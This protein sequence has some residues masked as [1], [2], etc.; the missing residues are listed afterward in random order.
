[1]ATSYKHAVSV[2]GQVFFC[3]A[4]IR[5]DAYDGCQFGCVY[6]FS[7]KRGRR[8]ND[9][10]IHK[11]NTDALSRRFARVRNGVIQSALDEFIS[12]RVP[13]QLGG[14]HDP[15]TE[16]ERNH[17][18]TLR[19]LEILNDYNYPTLISTKG[20][21]FSEPE[22][23]A[24]LQQMNVLVRISASGI[25]EDLRPKVDR[26]CSTFEATLDRIRKLKDAGIKSALRIQP[27]IPGFELESLEMARLAAQA[28][29]S[30]ISFEYLKVPK[31]SLKGEM[32]RLSAILGFDI[33]DRMRSYGLESVGWDLSLNANA[34]LP[35]LHS[36]RNACRANG[37][38]FGAGDTEFIPWSDSDGCCGSSDQ[39]LDKSTQ[40]T[41]NFVGAIKSAL[42]RKSRYV[43]IGDVWQGWHPTKSVG[44]YLDSAS[45]VQLA[46]GNESDW[47]ALISKRWNGG[48]GPYAPD[49]F[50]GVRWTGLFDG[51]G[52]KKYDVTNLR[53]LANAAP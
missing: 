2:S 10:G 15:F 24:L 50:Y 11:A 49:F 43:T 34:K 21:I 53:D 18:V 4:P 44:T 19:I 16:R 37:V 48:L 41:A 1:M 7:R 6:C 46:E 33:L 31:E 23:L 45:R 29:A 28:G 40:F 26:G 38:R 36:A 3:A 8:W 20:S 35:F 22:Y 52:F 14:L 27:V 42:K 30:Q 47:R 39:L 32:P 17:R 13:I 25:T 12:R 9:N 5:I 51:G